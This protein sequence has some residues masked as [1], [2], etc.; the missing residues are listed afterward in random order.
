MMQRDRVSETGRGEWDRATGQGMVREWL[1]IPNAPTRVVRLTGAAGMGKTHFLRAFLDEARIGDVSVLYVDGMSEE[2]TPGGV[3][4]MAEALGWIRGASTMA[5]EF[6]L[7]VVGGVKRAICVDHLDE[8]PQLRYWLQT[9][10]IPKLPS[11]NF[12]LMIA[13]RRLGRSAG[14]TARPESVC[15]DIH[16]TAFRRH[17]AWHELL[18]LGV[19]DV[20]WMYQLTQASGGHP[21]L[22]ARLAG[23]AEWDLDEQDMRADLSDVARGLLTELH[24]PALISSVEALCILGEANQDEIS[25]L[26][27]QPLGTEAYLALSDLSYVHWSPRGLYMEA[28]VATILRA[29]LRHRSPKR[30]DAW[31][32]RAVTVWEAQLAGL[33]GIEKAG[34]LAHMLG[35]H[36][37]RPAVENAVTLVG[38]RH[39]AQDVH[40]LHTD[41]AR[42][43]DGPFLHDLLRQGDSFQGGAFFRMETLHAW[44]EDLLKAGREQLLVTRDDQD[45]PVAMAWL[46]SISSKQFSSLPAGIRA[47]IRHQV[48]PWL[49]ST[50]SAVDR[51]DPFFVP[52]W[53]AREG[54]GMASAGD[55]WLALVAAVI[56]TLSESRRGLLWFHSDSAVPAI[57]SFDSHLSAQ[58]RKPVVAGTDGFSEAERGVCLDFYRTSL[59][60]WLR[61]WLPS[62][63]LKSASIRREAIRLGE[64]DIRDGLRHF[65][66]TQY[67]TE[68]AKRR[69]LDLNGDALRNRML[70]F[71]VTEQVPQPLTKEQQRILRVTYIDCPGNV[72]AIAHRL[73]LS[74]STYYRQLAEAHRNFADTF[75]V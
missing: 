53:V 44:L 35:L 63:S 34:T 39:S 46:V 72:E 32:V 23:R 74:R 49:M 36:G 20:S 66:H 3:L 28:G 16:L 9:T 7:S 8:R 21:G 2:A 50:A 61:G 22:L 51:V 54:E 12:M 60:E 25:V 55:T 33:S 59:G 41:A 24:L 52:L 40:R 69:E 45:R 70:G 4:R 31:L 48:E 65:H 68:F 10:L 27:D 73:A 43:T 14:L 30:L 47:Q 29:D 64:E 18:A 58:L 42:M 11:L 17:E 67:L 71:L 38:R 5:D 26:L 15:E 57:E 62:V 6:D 37:E 1:N 19:K 75:V 56:S 13:G